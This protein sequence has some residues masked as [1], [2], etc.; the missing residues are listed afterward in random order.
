MYVVS[1]IWIQ[2]MYIVYTDKQKAK[3]LNWIKHPSRWFINQKFQALLNS[4]HWKYI[5]VWNINTQT[6][7]NK[8]NQALTRA[9]HTHLRG[10]NR[11]VFEK[12]VSEFENFRVRLLILIW[13]YAYIYGWHWLLGFRKVYRNFRITVLLTGPLLASFLHC[14]IAPIFAG[15]RHRAGLTLT[16]ES[17]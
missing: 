7:L 11:R 13:W 2:M 10:F 8:S 12:N 14:T 9:D 4:P 5:Y 1:L 16:P 15:S 17:R 3:T 6:S